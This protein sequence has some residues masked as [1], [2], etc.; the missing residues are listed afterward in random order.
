MFDSFPTEPRNDV[1]DRVRCFFFD[2]G[3]DLAMAASLL[4]GAAAEARVISCA[5]QLEEA[6]R[7]D[8]R[9]RRDLAA[10]HRL[11]GLENVGDP[12][13][14]ETAFFS[15]LDP[16]SAEVE[17]ICLLTDRLEELLRDIDDRGSF[18]A[19]AEKDKPS[20]AA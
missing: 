7:V 3:H 9:I 15:E 10:F 20:I 4:G 18:S 16:A 1:L 11:L 5:I 19:K 6:Q 2:H 13:N 8:G 17:T 12:H 14:L